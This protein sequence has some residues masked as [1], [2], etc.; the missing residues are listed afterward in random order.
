MTAGR[1]KLKV[2]K[3]PMEKKETKASQNPEIWK[4]RVER[5][6]TEARKGCKDHK[7]CK[8]QQV[9]VVFLRAL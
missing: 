8:V 7:V 9:L 6:V 2:T 4:D 3:E 1:P 5:K